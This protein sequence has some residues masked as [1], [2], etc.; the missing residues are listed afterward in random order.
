MISHYLI[1]KYLNADRFPET[2]ETTTLGTEE[3]LSDGG[4]LGV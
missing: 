4:W 3:V 1:L 2:S